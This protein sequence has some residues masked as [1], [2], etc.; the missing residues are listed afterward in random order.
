MA[1]SC[2]TKSVMIRFQRVPTSR[3]DKEMTEHKDFSQRLSCIHSHK[4][5]PRQGRKG[6]HYIWPKLALGVPM[7]LLQH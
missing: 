1:S 4:H 7:Q 2:G 6:I 5:S 3:G